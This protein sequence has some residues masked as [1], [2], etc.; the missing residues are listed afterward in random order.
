MTTPVAGAAVLALMLFVLRLGAF[1]KCLGDLF[2][3]EAF[4]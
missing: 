3:F 1:D 2:C 4:S